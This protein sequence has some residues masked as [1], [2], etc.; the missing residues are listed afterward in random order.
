MTGWGGIAD[1]SPS[2]CEN[3]SAR[4]WRPVCL[5]QSW[6]LQRPCRNGGAMCVLIK[7]F[8]YTTCVSCTRGPFSVKTCH[9]T[10]RICTE[11]VRHRFHYSWSLRL[12][13]DRLIAFCQVIEQF[14]IVSNHMIICGVGHQRAIVAFRGSFESWTAA[15]AP[16][17]LNHIFDTDY[18]KSD[19]EINLFSSEGEWEQKAKSSITQTHFH[20]VRFSQIRLVASI[21]V[22]GGG[23]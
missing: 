1:T 20:R 10:N 15:S 5:Q 17:K 6:K 8:H 2:M 12:S 4:G 22:I 13:S 21:R 18:G 19:R 9:D 16:S 11:N 7:A 14:N 3:K 23:C